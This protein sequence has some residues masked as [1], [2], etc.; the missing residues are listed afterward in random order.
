VTKSER[1]EVGDALLVID[2][3]NA[4]GPTHRLEYMV[5]RMA[6]PQ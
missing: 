1:D 3:Q 2:D 4:G 6:S 5:G